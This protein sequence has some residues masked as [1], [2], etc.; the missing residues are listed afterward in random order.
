MT[1]ALQGHTPAWALCML[2]RVLLRRR[3][4]TSLLAYRHAWLFGP[5]TLQHGLY[6]CHGCMTGSNCCGRPGSTPVSALWM[7]ALAQLF[8]QHLH[9][10]DLHGLKQTCEQVTQA[11]QGDQHPSVAHALKPVAQLFWQQGD[12]STAVALLRCFRCGYLN[13]SSS[14]CCSTYF[15]RPVS[16]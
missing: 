10:L 2:P 16:R 11:A 15:S 14:S 4:N 1:C 9:W 8:W 3:G 12:D 13:L 5:S 6:M 7:L